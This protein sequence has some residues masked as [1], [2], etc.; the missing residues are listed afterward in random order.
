[1]PGMRPVPHAGGALA[2]SLQSHPEAHPDHPQPLCSTKRQRQLLTSMEEAEPLKL[3]Q[4]LSLVF[5]HF[6][7]LLVIPQAEVKG[8]NY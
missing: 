4:T 5:F 8:K 3:L 7:V 6:L 2:D 1:M